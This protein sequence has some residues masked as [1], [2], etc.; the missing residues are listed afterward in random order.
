MT[1]MKKLPVGSPETTP[2]TNAPPKIATKRS[3]TTTISKL[4]LKLISFSVNFPSA[5]S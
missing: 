3:D 4:V 5:A 2:P 1:V